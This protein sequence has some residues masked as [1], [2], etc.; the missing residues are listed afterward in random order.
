M[1]I[2]A[3]TKGKYWNKQVLINIMFCIYVYIFLFKKNPKR[4]WKQKKETLEYIS[5]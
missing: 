3:T 4:T 5:K 2:K 1:Y